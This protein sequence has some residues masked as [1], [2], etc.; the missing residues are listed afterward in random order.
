MSL[1]PPERRSLPGLPTDA[2]SL[3]QRD[4]AMQRLLVRLFVI[5]GTKRQ[6]G[7]DV[8]LDLVPVL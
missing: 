3:R 4:E 7:L 1:E 5:P 6:V 8:L 2:A